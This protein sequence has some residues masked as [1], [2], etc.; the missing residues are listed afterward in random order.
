MA[1]QT[2]LM[3]RDSCDRVPLLWSVIRRIRMSSNTKKMTALAAQKRTR[4]KLC[5]NTAEKA[6]LTR[7]QCVIF[8]GCAYSHNSKT[9]SGYDA[10]NE[11]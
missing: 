9:E 8:V 3:E 5:T 1:V 11:V 6:L 10:R 7:V 4:S 2:P